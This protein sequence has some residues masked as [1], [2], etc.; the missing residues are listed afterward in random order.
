MRRPEPNY[1]TEVAIAWCLVAVLKSGRG[2]Y[3][4]YQIGMHD[5]D[6]TDECG[7]G[8]DWEDEHF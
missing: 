4:F 1:K 8:E 3:R 7:D 6:T 2:V 5:E